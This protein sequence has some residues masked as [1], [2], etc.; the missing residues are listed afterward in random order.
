MAFLHFYCLGH[1]HDTSTCILDG[2]C[3]AE[4]VLHQHH[5]HWWSSGTICAFWLRFIGMHLAAPVQI[6]VTPT[7]SNFIACFTWKWS[8]LFFVS[9][10]E[11]PRLPEI[12]LKV[13]WN[14]LTLPLSAKVPSLIKAFIE[15]P[16]CMVLLY[17]F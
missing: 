12:F 3:F 8:V 5:L 10:R 14:A 11:W 6:L 9:P 7:A 2:N 17:N 15:E 13:P 4:V 16:C 1:Y